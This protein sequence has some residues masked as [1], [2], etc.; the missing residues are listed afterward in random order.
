MSTTVPNSLTTW[1][2]SHLSA[3]YHNQNSESDFPTTFNYTFSPSSEITVNDVLVSREA[4]MN[5]MSQFLKASPKVTIE[6]QNI[7]ELPKDRQNPNQVPFCS[8]V[9]AIFID[10]AVAG[11]DSGR[12]NADHSI[13]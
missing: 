9:C 4:F 13:S 7:S 2:Q 1:V 11:R 5:D 3:I 6:W 10:V 12:L 8:T